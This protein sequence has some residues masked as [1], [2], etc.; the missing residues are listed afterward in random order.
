MAVVETLERAQHAPPDRAAP[1]PRPQTAGQFR[2]CLTLHLGDE[3]YGIDILRV[4]E[5]RGY[6]APTRLANAPPF[7]KGVLNLRGIIVPV[8]DLRM[9]FGL[10]R[11][12]Y[13]PLT[14]TVIL[15]VAGRTLGA[16]VD[17]VSDV[18]ELTPQQIKPAPEF[19]HDIGAGHLVG[20]GVIPQGEGDG[21][22]ERMLI[23]VDI[24]HLMAS[25]DL[26][27]FAAAN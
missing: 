12:E 20:M 4:Q 2:E 21:K 27:L 3:E 25:S 22:P 6:E 10:E 5:I 26:G 1:P 13:S 11:V 18:I 16:V 14:V 9:K 8:V 23:L 7:I 15:N 17:G 24:E 19:D